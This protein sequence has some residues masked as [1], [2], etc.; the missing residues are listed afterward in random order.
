ML[1]CVVMK[2]WLPFVLGPQFAM[3]TLPG[4]ECLRGKWRGAGV[5]A[6]GGGGTCAQASE[7]AHRQQ[8]LATA[9]ITIGRQAPSLER[10]ALLLRP[11]RSLE[12]EVLVV[13]A[14]AVDGLGARAV[15]PGR[16]SGSGSGSG[17]GWRWGQ[18][19]G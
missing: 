15:V 4:A 8:T 16:G 17:W 19:R 10:G 14:R 12:L 2:N 7:Q 3:D 5:C 6:E 18:G 13:E 9:G 1:D 11:A